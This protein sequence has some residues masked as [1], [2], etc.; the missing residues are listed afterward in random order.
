MARIEIRMFEI[1]SE[2]PEEI[3]T[4]LHETFPGFLAKCMNDK[5]TY[6]ISYS[7]MANARFHHKYGYDIKEFVSIAFFKDP[8]RK[9]YKKRKLSVTKESDT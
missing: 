7:E 5:A 8:N 3:R 2:D 4:H 1:E 9:K 6:H